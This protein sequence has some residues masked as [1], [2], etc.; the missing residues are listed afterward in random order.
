ME[1]N[2]ILI[3]D[4]DS[5]ML[6]LCKEIFED[7]GYQVT[8][9]ESAEQAWPI[10]DSK[11]DEFDYILTDNDMPNTTGFELITRLR[12]LG[13]KSSLILMSGNPQP[14]NVDIIWNKNTHFIAKP[15]CPIIF[16]QIF[17]K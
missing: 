11:P 3:V 7:K 17:E 10:I 4:D 16:E 6:S 2:S 8:T 5:G 9:T 13:Y 14:D 1:V 12:H 15:F